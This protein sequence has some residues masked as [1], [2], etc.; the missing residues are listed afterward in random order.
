M[1]AKK[2]KDGHRVFLDKDDEEEECGSNELSGSSGKCQRKPDI[3]EG[4]SILK[5]DGGSANSGERCTS[6][7]DPFDSDDERNTRP[8]LDDARRA[9][10]MAI[11]TTGQSLSLGNGFQRFVRALNPLIP[12]SRSSLDQDVMDLY[13]RERNTLLS[14]ISEASG[15]LSFAVDKWRSKETG[16]NYNDDI[17]LCVAACF[18]DSDWKLQRRIVGFKH[19]EFPNDVVSVAETIALCISELKV[20]KKVISITLDNGTLDNEFYEA[21]MAHSLKSTLHDNC[22]LLCGGELCK[23]CVALIP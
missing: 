19:M 9:L 5:R 3:W 6:L 18:L 8:D 11:I 12:V 7:L 20:D 15:G 13:E 4:F 16:D 22:K 23:C 1:S 14:I 10:V 21:S 17:Y 2:S